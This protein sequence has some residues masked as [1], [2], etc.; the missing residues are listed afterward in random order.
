[1]ETSRPL[2]TVGE[3]AKQSGVTKPTVRSR[4][5]KAG[6]SLDELKGDDGVIRV[7]VDV[8]LAAGVPIGKPS[9]PDAQPKAGKADVELVQARAD[10]KVAEVRAAAAEALAAERA[11]RIA[12]LQREVERLAALATWLQLEVD[13][14]PARRAAT[15]GL[16]AG[17]ARKIW[18][19]GS[20]GNREPSQ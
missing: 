10:V 15:R 6:V 18:R 8:L 13:A 2:L 4:L 12:E 9:A 19:K 5:T 3:A 11:E 20:E 14:A 16:G 17:F 1:M 7:P